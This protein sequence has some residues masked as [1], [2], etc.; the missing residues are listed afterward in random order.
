LFTGPLEQAGL[1]YFVT[2]SVAS[3]IYGEPRMTH[4]VD[5]VLTLT[6]T[7]AANLLQA[8]PEE[9]FY[10]P[11]LEVVRI[12]LRRPVHGHF[13]LIHHESGFKADVYLAGRDPLHAWAMGRRRRASGVS[14]APE[15]PGKFS[16]Y[17]PGF[18]VA[19][20]EYVILRKLAWYR[21]GG[22]AKHLRDIRGMLAVVGSDLD[23]A[24][25]G[26]WI[27]VLGLE[28]EWRQLSFREP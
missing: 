22:S 14:A 4:D 18:W 11:P 9:A 25:L 21:E 15:W 13:N 24:E 7:E 28:A 26:R 19:P 10:V 2:G 3:L 6:D 8:F 17:E 27:G 5:L 1:S 16:E 12:E 23:M 20:P